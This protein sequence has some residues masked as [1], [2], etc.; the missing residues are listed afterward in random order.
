M[1]SEHANDEQ[2]QLFAIDSKACAP[3]VRAHINTCADCQAKA[4]DYRQ[5]MAAIEVQPLPLLDFDISELVLERLETKR[6]NWWIYVALAAAVLPIGIGMYYFRM[7]LFGGMNIFFIFLLAITAVC[8]VI[9]T[10]IDQVKN[11]RQK[12]NILATK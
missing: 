10:I 11:Y 1:T 6:S 7:Q 5:L 4:A 2:L 3:T 9:A 8:I 12:M